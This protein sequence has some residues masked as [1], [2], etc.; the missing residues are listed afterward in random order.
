MIEQEHHKKAFE[1]Y[2]SLG[3]GRSHQ[4]VAK[5]FGISLASVKLWGRS[6][7]WKYRIRQRDSE[8]A[9]TLA[10]RVI[11][12]EVSNRTRNKQI[13]QMALVRLAKA[14]AD[15]KVRM[16]LSD[17]DKLI[18]LDSF[19]NEKPNLQLDP[20]MEQIYDRIENDDRSEEE[21]MK[22]MEFNM[23][24][25]GYDVIKKEPLRLTVDSDTDEVSSDDQDDTS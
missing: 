12:D 6:F 8:V 13:V 24:V 15:G 3:E 22:E 9:R 21:I 10:T 14:I 23:R 20:L 2:Y 4:K 16:N 5:K 7:G 19:L 11:N 18:R 1:Y 25:L 17:L